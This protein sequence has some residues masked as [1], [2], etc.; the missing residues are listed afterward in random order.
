MLSNSLFSDAPI[1]TWAVLTS[2]LRSPTGEPDKRL[3]ELRQRI[4]DDVS[5]SSG[6]IPTDRGGRAR[7]LGSPF[8]LDDSDRNE[9]GNR[10][11]T[12]EGSPSVMVRREGG[13]AVSTSVLATSDAVLHGLQRAQRHGPFKGDGNQNVYLDE[14]PQR[15]VGVS[16][17]VGGSS[18]PEF[19]FP[20]DATVPDPFGGGEGAYVSFGEGFLWVRGRRLDPSMPPKSYVAFPVWGGELRVSGAGAS[21]EQGGL[22]F[23]EISSI[24][25]EFEINQ[26]ILGEECGF[27]TGPQIR[28]PEVIGIRVEQSGATWEALNS[29][30]GQLNAFGVE[31]GFEANGGQVVWV[32]DVQ[33][34]VLQ[35]E[36]LEGAG[37]VIEQIQHLDGQVLELDGSTMP[38]AFGMAFPVVVADADMLEAP[39]SPLAWWMEV[40]SG[41]QGRWYDSALPMHDLGALHL[42]F[43]PCIFH[44]V[45]PAVVP[46]RPVVDHKVALWETASSHRLPLHLRYPDPFLLQYRLDSRTNVSQRELLQV[47]G[48]A[49][50]ALDRPIDSSGTVIPFEAEEAELLLSVSPDSAEVISLL[51]TCTHAQAGINLEGGPTLGPPVQIALRNAVAW[52]LPPGLLI[53][54]GT[55]TNN[56]SPDAAV[57]TGSMALLM[58]LY[59]WAPTLPDPYVTN[60]TEDVF[61]RP[62]SDALPRAS[63]GADVRWTTPSDAALN[64]H[65]LI[66]RPDVSIETLEHSPTGIDETNGPKPT[67]TQS[68]QAIISS[69]SLRS[70]PAIGVGEDGTDLRQRF[71]NRAGMPAVRLLDVSTA[72]DYLGVDL[73][74]VRSYDGTAGL[75]EI[76][77]FEIAGLETRIRLRT[78]HTCAL[79]QHQWE[80]VRT[81]PAS[82][83][84]DLKK[85]INGADVF[86]LPDPIHSVDD[87]GPTRL[88]ADA[89]TR[90]PAVPE[91]TIAESVTAF[92]SGRKLSMLTT[93]P[94]GMTADVEFRVESD[95]D[96]DTVTLNRPEFSN[97]RGGLHLTAEAEHKRTD[98]GG[99]SPMFKGSTVQTT[100]GVSL[101]DPRSTKTSVLG[102]HSQS[103]SVGRLFNEEFD[104]PDG[105]VPVGRL[106]TS[107]YGASLFTDWSDPFAAYA[108]IAKVQFRTIGGRTVTEVVKATTMLHPWGVRVTR[109]ITIERRNGGGVI[110]RDSGWQPASD[111]LFDFRYK[112]TSGTLL[113]PDYPYNAGLFRGLRNV[114]NIRKKTEGSP[115]ESDGATFV[116]YVL[117]ADIQFDGAPETTPCTGILCYLQSEPTGEPAP[118]TSVENLLRDRGPIGGTV[119]TEIAVGDS[120]LPFRVRRFEVALATTN[121][122]TFVAVLRGLPRLSQSGSWTVTRR[123]TSNDDAGGGT[124]ESVQGM[125]LVYSAP[126]EYETDT[127]GPNIPLGPLGDTYYFADGEDLLRLLNGGTPQVEYG[128]VQTSAAHSFLFPNPQV[129]DGEGFVRTG[130]DKVYVVDLFSKASSKG[131]FPPLDTAIEFTPVS[132]FGLKP[133]SNGLQFIE[134]GHPKPVSRDGVSKTTWLDGSEG[135][136]NL[137]EYGPDSKITYK[138]DDTDQAEPWAVGFEDV[139]LWN[140]LFGLHRVIGTQIRYD[141]SGGSPANLSYRV[142]FFEALEKLLAVIPGFNQQDDFTGPVPIG[143]SNLKGDLSIEFGLSITLNFRVGPDKITLR[144]GYLHRFGKSI[145]GPEDGSALYGMSYKDSFTLDTRFYTKAIPPI[146]AVI[147]VRLIYSLTKEFTF[148]EGGFD[149]SNKQEVAIAVYIGIGESVNIGPAKGEALLAFGIELVITSGDVTPSLILIAEL[150]LKINKIGVKGV[151]EAKGT[152]KENKAKA[153]VKGKISVELKKLLSIDLSVKYKTE[154]KLSS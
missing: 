4:Y 116:P 65:G 107:G 59:R 23:S 32:E 41:M 147:G 145:A 46:R 72:Q 138:L 35:S 103:D 38:V 153:T 51:L 63:L 123:E 31:V 110:R 30:E 120:N 128:F 47:N 55:L 108:D 121:D 68:Q 88:H 126:V 129:R 127:E 132:P 61:L 48:S 106:D 76:A 142:R 49:Q 19:V 94:F 70:D 73:D 92:D 56:F 12:S 100:N 84:I 112:D 16:I 98:D 105:G 151:F 75:D 78:L 43:E 111:G 53:L 60:V 89:P 67:R 143:A 2:D 152:I 54:E 80:P 118:Q 74:N 87:G 81:D 133:V 15:E 140:D 113:D 115:Y 34:V 5:S 150:K 52:V 96:A 7:L 83:Q 17:Y 144:L 14:Y 9:L 137:I 86:A 93:L 131:T 125:P 58:G 64:F 90:V 28:I 146:P 95:P 99:V 11:Q 130:E 119:D 37:Q 40:E 82:K 71:K 134:S 101:D 25:V 20:E 124:V 77:S 10:L 3:G 24:T 1:D 62:E 50:A 139:D 154:K 102:D 117:D 45:A 42:L 66:G 85:D 8:Y 148:V 141:A 27:G 13:T 26:D 135:S 36:I 109:A 122:P 104:K 97:R 21:E 57:D 79:P 69:S 91:N 44:L 18:Q 6:V 149:R 29:P 22:R 136:G 33:R 114:R 39:T